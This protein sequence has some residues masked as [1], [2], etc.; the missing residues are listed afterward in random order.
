[1][2]HVSILKRK[3]QVITLGKSSCLLRLYAFKIKSQLS[4]YNFQGLEQLD[5]NRGGLQV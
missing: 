1:M 5:V 3:Q 2:Q 4:F